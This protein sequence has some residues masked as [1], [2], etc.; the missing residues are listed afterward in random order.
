MPNSILCSVRL[1][2]TMLSDADA[3]LLA[4]RYGDGLTID[5]GADARRG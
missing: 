4:A 2:S 1:S 3:R 5:R